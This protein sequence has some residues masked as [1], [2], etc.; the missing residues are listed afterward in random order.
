MLAAWGN[1]RF[2]QRG[3]AAASAAAEA[4]APDKDTM[5]EHLRQRV[6]ATLADIKTITLSTSGPAGVQASRLPC[7]AQELELYVL[8]P[9]ASDHLFN[10]SAQPD[11]AVVDD[12][13]NVSGQARVAPPGACPPALAQRPE[14]EWSEVVVVRPFR[15]TLFCRETGTPVET[16]DVD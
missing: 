1:Q 4:A 10:L 3:G 16:I 2:P 11:V 9:A 14:A 5:L 7:A 15:V 12:T 13:W 8:V 6:I